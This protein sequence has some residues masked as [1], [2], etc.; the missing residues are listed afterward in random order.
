MEI[1][2]YVD[3]KVL[4]MKLNPDSGPRGTR[5]SIPQ[6]PYKPHPPTESDRE[7]KILPQ[8][9]GDKCNPLCPLFTCTRNALFVVNKPI[10]GRLM[11]VAQ[12]RLTGGDCINGECQ[13]SSCRVNSLLPDGKCAKALEKKITRPSDEEIFREMM[14][15]EEY[16]VSDFR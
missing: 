5:P 4:S 13:Y 6:R 10:K 12:C 15:V 1:K 14:R 3:A 7:K 2:A 9:I 11:R 16:D 8:P